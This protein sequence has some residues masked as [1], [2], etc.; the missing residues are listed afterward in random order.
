MGEIGSGFMDLVT[1]AAQSISII[2]AGDPGVIRL[3]VP[4]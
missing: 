1:Q 3:D 2:A 4:V